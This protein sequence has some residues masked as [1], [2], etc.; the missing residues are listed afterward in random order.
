MIQAMTN[1]NLQQKI[2]C[3]SE[4]DFINFEIGTI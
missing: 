2:V 1:L 4:N 3:H